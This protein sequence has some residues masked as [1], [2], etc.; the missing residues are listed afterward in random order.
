[1]RTEIDKNWNFDESEAEIEGIGRCFVQYNNIKRQSLNND[2]MKQETIPLSELPVLTSNI[3]RAIC[4]LA[5]SLYNIADEEEKT[6]KYLLRT[7]R[8]KFLLRK[9]GNIIRKLTCEE[10][11]V[12]K[13]Q[14]FFEGFVLSSKSFKGEL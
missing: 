14:V 6:A 11:I 12:I 3:K 13:S 1:M 7:Q 2:F 10:T 8:E 4:M 5:W 9:D